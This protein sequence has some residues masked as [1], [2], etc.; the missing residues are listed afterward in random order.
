MNK[1]VENKI[2]ALIEEAVHANHPE[3]DKSKLGR[4][5]TSDRKGNSIRQNR[6]ALASHIKGERKVRD[7]MRT[8]I[9]NRRSLVLDGE[10]DFD[11][12]NR[13]QDYGNAQ[14]RLANK[15][16]NGARLSSVKGKPT[17]YI[18]RH[19]GGWEGPQTAY[20]DPVRQ[21]EV[22]MSLDGRDVRD[23]ALAVKE[24]NSIKNKVKS[25]ANSILRK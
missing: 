12:R 17:E 13:M 16:D 7:D 4:M 21:R 22:K 15:S 8:S 24:Q 1:I 9:Q 3:L 5:F 14:F 11:T 19:L 18:P 10:G 20:A 2:D 23:E 6:D 25:V